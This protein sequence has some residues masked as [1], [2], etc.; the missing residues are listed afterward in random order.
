MM[1]PG[2]PFM[3]LGRN[4]CLAWG[5]TN[6]RAASSD[7]YDVTEID[8]AKVA[9]SVTK[10]SQRFWFSTER[11]IRIT[12]FGPI[13]SDSSL[14]P[15]A[16]GRSIALRWIGHTNTDEISAFLNASR[17]C[18]ADQFRSAFSTFGVSAQNM[19]FA[20]ATG[21]IGQVAAAIVPSRP[22]RFSHSG[23]ILKPGDTNSDWNDLQNSL[24]LPMALN[25]KSGFLASANNKPTNFGPSIGFTFSADD[26]ISRLKELIYGRDQI[27]VPFLMSLQRDVKSMAAQRMARVIVQQIKE[28]S[29]AAVNPEIV[30]QLDSWTGDYDAQSR[31]ALLFEFIYVDLAQNGFTNEEGEDVAKAYQ[32]WS[33]AE[34]YFERDFLALSRENRRKALKESLSR[35]TKHAGRAKVWGDFHRLSV[36]HPL[37]AVPLLGRFFVEADLPAS[38]SRETI[39]KTAHGLTS[40]RHNAQYGSQSRHISDL[41]DP[42]ANYFVL[43]GGQDGWLGSANFSDQLALWSSGE[44]V[45][46]PLRIETI[47]NDFKKRMELTPQEKFNRSPN[48]HAEEAALPQYQNK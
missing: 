47:K 39:M 16:A 27:D 18:T 30:A 7:L 23:F 11:K 22:N 26:R 5:G 10:I 2:L 31:A 29:L 3:G 32:Q 19:L 21:D 13:L 1:I 12:P 4:E 34:R 48:V 35:A 24:D 9:E 36:G 14:F 20:T 17:A 6:M 37:A 41:S 43:L 25:P 40:D 42:D 8:S 33:Y 38:G 44:Y 46:V 15:S 45:R 28:L